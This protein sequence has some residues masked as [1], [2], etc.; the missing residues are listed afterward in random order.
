ME[1]TEKMAVDN[2]EIIAEDGPKNGDVAVIVDFMKQPMDVWHQIFGLL[3]VKD[4]VKLTQL[5]KSW[6]KFIDSNATL[7][8]NLCQKDFPGKAFV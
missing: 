8:K 1:E 2:Q 6:N 5:N 7:W 4:I 3:R